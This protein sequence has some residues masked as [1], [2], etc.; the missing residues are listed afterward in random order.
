MPKHG[1]RGNLEFPDF[2]KRKFYSINYWYCPSICTLIFGW[3]VTGVPIFSP[4]F[5]PWPLKLPPVI[6]LIRLDKESQIN[7]SQNQKSRLRFYIEN[8]PLKITLH[9]FKAFWLVENYLNLSLKFF[10]VSGSDQPCL[11]ML[12]NTSAASKMT[13]WDR[14]VVAKHALRHVL[15]E[16]LQP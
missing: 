6:T 9:L 12:L 2:L 4:P 5:L 14:R 7:P 8:F 1:F 11:K 3:E 10:T 13:S 15:L 16:L